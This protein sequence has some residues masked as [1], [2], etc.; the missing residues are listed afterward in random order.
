[1]PPLVQAD[2][3]TKKF[4]SS[5]AVQDVTLSLQPGQALGLLGPNGA[6][7]TTTMRMLQGAL[8]PTAGSVSINGRHP[9]EVP[10]IDHAIGFAFDGTGLPSG[11]SVR[12]H[13][14][15][16]ALAA[17]IGRDRLNELIEEFELGGL[18][19]RRIKQLSTG[20]RKRVT[21]ATAVAA[22][23]RI[24]VLDEPTNGLDIEGAHWI[25]QVLLSHIAD[26]GSLLISSHILGEV[27]Q[28]VDSIVVIKQTQVFS[29]SLS[30][31]R[32]RGTTSLEEA[33]LSLVNP[34]TRSLAA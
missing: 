33:Y 2:H 18:L 28:V 34:T 31:L 20:E 10:H 32:N 21:L 22:R 11:Q 6:G 12:N 25:R 23:P 24:L 17:G 14:A 15:T 26:G 1:M 19:R 27:E 3:V 5:T 16:H 30:E 13:L 9:L 7:K 8:Q 4:R 29:G